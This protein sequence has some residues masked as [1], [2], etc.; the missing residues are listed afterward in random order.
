MIPFDADRVEAVLL[1]DQTWRDIE[2]GSYTPLEG[3]AAFSFTAKEGTHVFAGPLSSI[4]AV[5]YADAL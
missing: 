3:G 1:P 2:P 4:L 5:R